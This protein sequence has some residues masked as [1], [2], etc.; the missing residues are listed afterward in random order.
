MSVLTDFAADVNTEMLRG[1]ISESITYAPAGAAAISTY[2]VVD[3]QSD[4]G[5]VTGGVGHVAAFTVSKAAVSDPNIYDTITYGGN[6][7]AVRTVV[8]GT[9]GVWTIV[10]ER[11]RRQ[12]PDGMS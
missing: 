2:A 8:S 4:Q 12:L 11:L 7:F 9:G 10:A 6:T 5:Q 1:D 3:V